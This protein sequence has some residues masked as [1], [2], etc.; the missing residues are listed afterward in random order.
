MYTEDQL[1]TNFSPKSRTKRA[2]LLPILIGA[3][4]VTGIGTGIGGVSSSIGLYHRL[5]QELN[6]DTERVAD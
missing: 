5:S 6:E 4:I 1:L 3:G 2:I